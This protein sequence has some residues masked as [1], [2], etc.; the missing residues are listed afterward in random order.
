MVW[1]KSVQ[2]GA[3]NHRLALRDEL[4]FKDRTGVGLAAAGEGQK[5]KKSR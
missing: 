5:G 1:A 4:S 3:I 2:N